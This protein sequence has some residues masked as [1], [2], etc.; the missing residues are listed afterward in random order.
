[1]LEHVNAGTYQVF[2]E[3]EDTRHRM[4]LSF[5]KMGGLPEQEGRANLVDCTLISRFS[6]RKELV[7]SC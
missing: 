4:N 7:K 5:I 6:V 1:M 3:D 2:D